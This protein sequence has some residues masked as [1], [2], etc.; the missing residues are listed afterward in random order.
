MEG[1][2]FADFKER[3]GLGT[4]AQARTRTEDATMYCLT[5]I[6]RPRKCFCILR[7]FFIAY[8]NSYAEETSDPTKQEGK[9]VSEPDRESKIELEA[10]FNRLEKDINE[11]ITTSWTCFDLHPK[12]M[13]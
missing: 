3:T 11:G 4:C 10:D 5:R 8:D 9:R 7:F 2:G 6:C 12:S 1:Y 13:Q